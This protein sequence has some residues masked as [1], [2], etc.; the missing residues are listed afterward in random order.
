MELTDMWFFFICPILLLIF[1]NFQ[2]YL[3]A[4]GKGRTAEVQRDARI[5]ETEAKR[6]ATIQKCIASEE[7][8]KAKFAN[9]TLVAQAERDFQLKKATYDQEVQAKVPTHNYLLVMCYYLK[10]VSV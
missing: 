3:E 4:L 5:G 8:L 1:I 10:D 7:L 9:D 6:D 2:G